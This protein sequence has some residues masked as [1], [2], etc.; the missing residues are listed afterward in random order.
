MVLDHLCS[1][2]HFLLVSV[3]WSYLNKQSL[4]M[5]VYTLQQLLLEQKG[6]RSGSMLSRNSKPYINI[7]P[8]HVVYPHNSMHMLIR[9][10]VFDVLRPVCISELSEKHIITVAIFQTLQF[11]L[12]VRRS[13]LDKLLWTVSTAL[14]FQPSRTGAG[15]RLE[16]CGSGG[17]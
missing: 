4:L 13:G 8:T 3:C 10:C 1:F 5:Y 9:C 15:I 17:C 14:S 6:Q 12:N 16:Q 7:T 11:K 2:A